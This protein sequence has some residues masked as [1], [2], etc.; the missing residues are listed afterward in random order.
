MFKIY[1]ANCLHQESKKIKETKN[2]VLFEVI[3]GSIM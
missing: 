2:K 3:Y 1:K